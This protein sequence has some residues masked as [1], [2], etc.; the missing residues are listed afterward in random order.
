[1]F[2]IGREQKIFYQL[3]QNW[4]KTLNLNKWRDYAMFLGGKQIMYNDN[5]M[6]YYIIIKTVSPS[7]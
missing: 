2:L 6:A 4:H 1:M 3:S 5:A 7:N